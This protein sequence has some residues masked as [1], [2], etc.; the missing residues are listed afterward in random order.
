MVKLA[1]PATKIMKMMILTKMHLKEEAE[2]NIG[3]IKKMMMK[4]ITMN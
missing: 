4:M 2:N 1:V 3:K